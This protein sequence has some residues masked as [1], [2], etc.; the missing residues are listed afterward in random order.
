MKINL[1]L[2][3]FSAKSSIKKRMKSQKSRKR[4]DSVSLISLIS[5]NSEDIKIISLV[6]F[7]E[8]TK[9]SEAEIIIITPENIEK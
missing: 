9:K 5:S 1:R 8:L 7:K 2:I 3:S 6:V 4:R